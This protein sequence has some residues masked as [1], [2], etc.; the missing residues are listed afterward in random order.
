MLEKKAIQVATS[1]VK[2]RF[3]SNLFVT[4]KKD[5]GFRP[6]INLKRL[7]KAIPYQHFQ[8]EGLKNVQDLI[9]PMDY[10]IKIGPI[11][12]ILQCP[13]TQ[14]LQET[15]LL[16]LERNSL[17]IQSPLLRPKQCSQDL[18]KASES[19]IGLPK[20]A[21]LTSCDLSRRPDPVRAIQGGSDSSKGCC[22]TGPDQSRLYY[23]SKEKHPLSH[24]VPHL[25]GDRSEFE[26]NDFCSSRGKDQEPSS[27]LPKV[28]FSVLPNQRPILLGRET[29]SDHASCL[30]SIATSKIPTEVPHLY[31]AVSDDGPTFR[32]QVGISRVSKTWSPEFVSRHPNPSRE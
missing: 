9:E 10:L 25:S 21:L 15:D 3:F 5:G 12:R 16:S 11:G 24:P 8:M 31:E 20:K 14:G 32:G 19:S 26:G 13:S 30:N 29:D 18:L 28:D 2:G 23:Q 4:T 6:V 27:L 1:T 17:R 22:N 7:N